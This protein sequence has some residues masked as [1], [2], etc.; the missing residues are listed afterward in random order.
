MNVNF[1]ELQIYTLA[2]ALVLDFYRELKKFPE[3]ESNNLVSQIRRAV[4]CLPLNIA[5]GSG[6]GSPK[7]FL[8]YLT[9]CYRSCMEVEAA[10]RLAYDLDYVDTVAYEVRFSQLD[11]FIRKLYRYMQYIE[12][13][14]PSKRDKTYY[15]KFEKHKIDE[16]MNN[17]SKK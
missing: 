3:Y 5:E 14:C 15:Y 9:F 1:R 10:W 7:L 2:H 11:T 6:G 17:R 8:H 4:T 13:F 16:Q 12:G